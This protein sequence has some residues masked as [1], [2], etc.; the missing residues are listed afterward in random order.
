MPNE[1]EIE[2]AVLTER[3]EALRADHLQLSASIRELSRTV[4][5][6]E[7]AVASQSPLTNLFERLVTV[8]LTAAGT[9]WITRDSK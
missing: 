1:R 4:S 8:A 5:A 3:L 7:R 6:L 9:W 2:V